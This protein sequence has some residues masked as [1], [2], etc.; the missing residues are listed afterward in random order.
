MKA[1]TRREALS[2]LALTGATLAAWPESAAS[3]LS[4]GPQ[5]DMRQL[6]KA[7][8]GVHNFVIT[9]FRANYDLDAEGLYKNVDFHTRNPAFHPRPG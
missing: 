9:P 1:I 4:T 8:S 2:R 5:R 6:G 3:M 7:L